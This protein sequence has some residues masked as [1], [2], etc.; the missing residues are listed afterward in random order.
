MMCI[1]STAIVIATP[2]CNR[3]GNIRLGT[4]LL[5]GGE[6]QHLIQFDAWQHDSEHWPPDSRGRMRLGAQFPIVASSGG[7]CRF[8][9]GHLPAGQRRSHALRI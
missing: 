9:E 7:W 2:L 1:R 4:W 6:L 3:E 5:Q 8:S